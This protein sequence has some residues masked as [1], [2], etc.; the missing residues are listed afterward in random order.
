MNDKP[1]PPLGFRDFLQDLRRGDP[2]FWLVAALVAL[3]FL[4]YWLTH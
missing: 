4:S 1:K 3:R 2:L